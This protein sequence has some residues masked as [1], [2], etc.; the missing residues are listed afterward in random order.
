MTLA[1]VFNPF[2][3][4]LILLSGL[5]A[6]FALSAGLLALPGT[7]A[8]QLAARNAAPNQRAASLLSPLWIVAGVVGGGIFV[9]VFGPG[10]HFNPG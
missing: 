7:A 4:Q 10:I 5:G 8:N 9:G 1:S 2:G 3:R 6:S